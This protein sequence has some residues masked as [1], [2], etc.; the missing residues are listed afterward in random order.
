[1]KF[2]QLATNSDF[3][4]LPST[5]SILDQRSMCRTFLSL[6]SMSKLSCHRLPA[7]AQ[8]CFLMPVLTENIWLDAM[9][10]LFGKLFIILFG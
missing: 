5:K 7:L 1:M 8:P 4:F 10:Q 9:P 3:L 2:G 6:T